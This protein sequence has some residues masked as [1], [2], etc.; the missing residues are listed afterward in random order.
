MKDRASERIEFVNVN[1]S[2][3]PALFDLSKTGVCCFSAKKL[4]KGAVAS[5]TINKLS[6]KARVIYSQDRLDGFRVGMQFIEV[7]PQQQETLNDL[8][9]KF[10]RGVPLSCTIE[11]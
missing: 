2:Q 8:V 6:I 9:D 10:S 1:G 7:T 4:D 5:L 3:V 11:G